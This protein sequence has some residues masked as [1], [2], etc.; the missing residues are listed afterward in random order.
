[1]ATQPGDEQVLHRLDTSFTSLD[2]ERAERLKR[3]QL[4]Q[5]NKDNALKREQARLQKKYGADHPRVLKI[6][7][8]LAYNT[9]AIPELAAEVT[10][11]DVNTPEF[12]P[13]TWMVHG[14]VLNQKG[15]G[16]KGLTLALHNEMGKVERRVGYTCTDERGYYAIRYTVQQGDT[17][18]DEHANYYLTVSDGTGK[19]CYK[20]KR[21]INV[22]IGRMDYRPILLDG[23]KCVLPPGWDEG[24]DDDVVSDAWIVRGNVS[25]DDKQPGA[26]LTV[27]LYD[28]DLLFDDQ[29]GTTQTDADGNFRI[30]YRTEA[31]RDLLEEKP[32]LYLKVLDASGKVLYGSRKS[33]RSEA[34]RVEEFKITL[35]RQ[36]GES[37]K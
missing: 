8:R 6:N 25:Y 24:S 14:R 1:M 11:A 13:D 2:N 17:P 37:K 20:E 9:V 34:G 26:G 16:I 3:T 35:K 36:A 27:S 30:I 5:T 23:T 29:L 28:K 18:I 12:T 7:N 19:L 15:E 22:V 21:P 33:V 31:F 4:L 10:R 32:D